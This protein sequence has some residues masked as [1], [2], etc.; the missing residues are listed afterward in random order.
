LPHVPV[1]QLEP[2]AEHEHHEAD[3][4]QD[5]EERSARDWEQAGGQLPGQQAQ[6]RRPERDAGQDL[7]DHRRLAPAHSDRAEATAHGDH[8]GEVK[9][10]VCGVRQGRGHTVTP[11]AR[12]FS[13]DIIT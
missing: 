12:S 5:G 3:V 8:Q 9:E 7:A 1:I 11:A 10:N 6:E 2:D 13:D 4:G